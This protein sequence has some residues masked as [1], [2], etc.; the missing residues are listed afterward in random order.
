MAVNPNTD[1]TV[2]QVLTAAQQN[3][4]PRGVMAFAS[5]ATNFSITT[6]ETAATGMSVTFTAVANRYYK[7]TYFEPNIYLGASNQVNAGIRLTNTSGTLYQS[8]AGGGNVGFAQGLHCAVV[9]TFTAGSKTLIGS[10]KVNGGTG[11]AGRSATEVAFMLVEDL[12]P[13]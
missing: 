6:T 10:L 2:G 13:A 1:F 7:V 12:G 5:S 11:N 4:F 3:R 8:M 9:T